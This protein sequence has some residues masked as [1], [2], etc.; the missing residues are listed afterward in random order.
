[1]NSDNSNSTLSSLAGISTATRDQREN[2]LLTIVKA[3]IVFL[4]STLTEDNF[5][6]NQ[7]EIRSVSAT[8]LASTFLVAF[9]WCHLVFFVTF[10]LICVSYFQ[11]SETHGI[12][13]YLHFIRR[14]IIAAQSRG[15]MSAQ[16]NAYETPTTLAI[17][18]LV[19]ETQRLA[20]DPFLAERF[21]DAVD[22]GEGDFF[23]HFDLTKFM[24]RTGLRPLER[25]ILASSIVAHNCRKDLVI[26]ANNIIRADWANAIMSLCNHP[27]FDHA[28]LTPSQVA[29]LLSILLSDPPADSPILDPTQRLELIVAAQT[30]CGSE[31]M[32]P[33][34][35]QIFPTIR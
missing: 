35:Q 34:L 16:Q 22:K 19:Q 14:L 10:K 9:V 11:L 12:E 3:Q 33:I 26:Q 7:M 30:K 6:R 15:P 17:R 13:T 25:L 1:M 21:R 27:S 28:D 23:R 18:L 8:T 31:L 29:K 24:D 20:R 5:D 32:G 4:L 2:S